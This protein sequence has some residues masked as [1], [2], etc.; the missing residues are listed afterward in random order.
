MN[1]KDK[2]I[3]STVDK[4]TGVL[5]FLVVA[6]IPLVV[7]QSNIDVSQYEYGIIR[8]SSVVADV[9]SYNKAVLL[10]IVAGCIIIY[11]FL[12]LIT[13]NDFEF[14]LQY[15]NKAVI[16]VFVYGLL[17]VLSTLF[18]SYKYVAVNGISERYEGLLVMISYVV[19]FVTA[20]H[21]ADNEK[22]LKWVLTAFGVSSLLIG[23]V[24]AFQ[25]FGMDIFKTE[26]MAKLVQGSY[27]K[28]G[29]LLGI[30][31]NS[32]YTT[33]YNPN[34]VGLYTAMMFPFMT[35][36]AFLLP[37]KSYYKYIFGS[38]AVLMGI[39][40][41]GSGSL[42]GF[43]GVIA[44]FVFCLI[45]A[46]IYYFYKRVYKTMSIKMAMGIAV[47]AVVIAFAGIG[48]VGSK[49]NVVEKLRIVMEAVK[50]PEL[51]TNPNFFEDMD[52][53]GD[54]ANIYTKT[55]II[56]LVNNDG[57]VDLLQND[58]L[59]SPVSESAMSDIENGRVLTYNVDGLSRGE[60]QLYDDK[61]VFIG[62]D[63]N[64]SA[65][66][67]LFGVVGDTFTGLD[68]FGSPVDINEGVKSV[69]FEGIE[70]LGSSR[71]YIWSRS[72]PLIA[73]NIII[74]KGP[75]TFSLEFPQE[76]TKG[77]LIS[78]GNPYVI[79]DKPHNMYLQIAINTGLLSLLAVLALAVIYVVQT[80]SRIFKDKSSKLVFC[81]RWAILSGVIGYMAAGLTTDSVVSVAPVFWVMLGMGYA[82]NSI[83]TQ[84]E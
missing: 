2:H 78:F 49:A 19:F 26:L 55:G 3:N 18:S 76:D 70:R 20:L 53:Q 66:H 64:E 30:K 50:N 24:G 4:V 38:L 14:K 21:Y 17:G 51:L 57:N 43:V 67:F 65:T 40:L 37:I 45:L 33:L 52:I 12:G 13:S 5:L 80:I 22:A 9:F 29:T 72:I 31:Y 47:C 68:K 6:I 41:I 59:L 28:E 82:V 11:K 74:G 73:E 44:T 1:I 42:G 39:N 8:S 27:Y 83:R 60:L 56:T 36:L 61:A 75:D 54:R 35:M 62:Y 77:K 58:T 25:Y 15:R 63:E 84:G 7:R 79:V 81:V 23:L 10:C 71:G 16:L 48:A 46:V 32:V 34:C 69:G